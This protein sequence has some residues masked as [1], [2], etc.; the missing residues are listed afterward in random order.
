MRNVL[1]IIAIVA[2]S[3]QAQ[4]SPVRATAKT[5]RVLWEYKV[6]TAYYDH[7]EDESLAKLSADGWELVS[8]AYVE[9]LMTGKSEHPVNTNPGKLAPHLRYY[10]KRQK[11]QSSP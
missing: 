6:A 2:I 8:V 4:D 7:Q 3:V 1:L 5:S 10:F 11:E 9:A